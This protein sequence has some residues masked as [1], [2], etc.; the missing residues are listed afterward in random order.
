MERIDVEDLLRPHS[1]D[2]PH[3]DTAPLETGDRLADDPEVR[4]RFRAGA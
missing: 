2:G 1:V 3:L 4:A